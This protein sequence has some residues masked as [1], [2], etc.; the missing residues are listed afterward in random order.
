LSVLF[1]ILS[2]GVVWEECFKLL[3]ELLILLGLLRKV[4]V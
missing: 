2:A 4:S 3:A 1:D